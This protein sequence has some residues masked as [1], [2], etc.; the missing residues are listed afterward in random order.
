[1]NDL[2]TVL[3]EGQVST[4]ESMIIFA[5][6]G[7]FYDVF[8]EHRFFLFWSVRHLYRFFYG[9]KW[10]NALDQSEAL[11][12]QGGLPVFFSTTTCDVA[13]FMSMWVLQR[14]TLHDIDN[15][16]WCCAAKS[17]YVNMRWL[18]ALCEVLHFKVSEEDLTV[19]FEPKLVHAPSTR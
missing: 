18:A 6:T 4:S 7:K 17:G 1:M 2:M 14:W 12:E 3:H 11:H 19:Q 8:S 16:F 15:D 5:A 10:E 9:S 13:D